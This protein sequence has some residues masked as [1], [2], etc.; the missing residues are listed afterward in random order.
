MLTGLDKIVKFGN[1]VSAGSSTMGSLFGADDLPD[2]E[3]PKIPPCDPWPLILKLNNEREVTGIYISGHPLDDYRFESRFYNMNTVQDLVE[4]NADL[5]TPG[6]GRP[7]R[8][9]NFRL[10]V[11]VTGAQER[12]SRNNRQFGIMTIED[13]TGKFEFALWSEDFIR[14]APYL[15]PG[16]C[17]FIN[18]GF[19]AKRFND[20]EYEF[21]VGSIQLLQEVKKTHTK[22]VGLVTMPKFITREFVDFLV[23]NMAKYPGASEL[24]LQ[25]ID[26][27]N[28]MA[29]K[30]HTFNKHIEMNDELAHYL[31]QQRDID[32]YIE[33]INK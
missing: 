2:V 14:F 15:K 32:I 1:Q 29:V 33:T 10:A 12:I 11:Y 4:Y 9:R 23:D 31:T 16:L 28:G 5:S 19:K 17:L 8:E 13:Y 25:L 24:Y 30:L 20:S 22:K 3:P 21:K 7:G 26:R 6:N 18:G 27:D